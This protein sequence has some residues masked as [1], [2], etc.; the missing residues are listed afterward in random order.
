MI[1]NS[2]ESKRMVLGLPFAQRRALEK[3][4]QRELQK[5]LQ[6]DRESNERDSQKDSTENTTHVLGE[7]PSSP[8]PFPQTRTGSHNA[9]LVSRKKVPALHHKLN[10]DKAILE[11]EFEILR[12][13]PGRD[14]SHHIIPQSVKK[15]CKPPTQSAEMPI[16]AAGQYKSSPVDIPQHAD[17]DPL[18]VLVDRNKCPGYEICN[19]S[20]VDNPHY[21]SMQ[22][23][24]RTNKK[25]MTKPTVFKR[26]LD[27]EWVRADECNK[28]RRKD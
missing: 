28:M 24:G 1:E 18:Q 17:R 19:H 9:K 20:F 22:A 14:R 8:I 27:G 16:V 23:P 6:M 2:S 7:A 21:H 25:Q 4:Q 12:R 15:G 11:Q 5:L 3:N 13:M 10:N 26:F